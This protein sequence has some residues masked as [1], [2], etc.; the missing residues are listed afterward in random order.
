MVDS[1]GMAAGRG[2]YACPTVECLDKA[3]IPGR[4]GHALKGAAQPPRESA[5]EI[6]QDWRR[7]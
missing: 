2:A 6:A 4:L 5:A 3:L 7:R 1:P